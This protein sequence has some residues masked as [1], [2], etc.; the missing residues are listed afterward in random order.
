MA[1]RGAR[2]LNATAEQTWDTTGQG[3]DGIAEND[4][5]R[6]RAKLTRNST[7]STSTPS[8]LRTTLVSAAEPLTGAASGDV[9]KSGSPVADQ[10]GVWASG[11][12]IEGDPSL[13]YDA[14]TATL[15]VWENLA[16]PTD[17]MSFSHNGTNGLIASN[18]N[19]LFGPSGAGY[20]HGM[21]STH[22]WTNGTFFFLGKTGP[23][24]AVPNFGQLWV[25]DN[26]DLNDLWFSDENGLDRPIGYAA[27]R[28]EEV[29]EV[30]VLDH[31]NVSGETIGAQHING[32]WH[33]T[34]STSRTLLLETSS[35]FN[36]PV[37]AQLAIYNR[38]AAGNLTIND[39]ATQTLYLLDG[40]TSTDVG[41]SVIIGP[42][43]YATLIRESADAS[44]I[45]GAGL[46]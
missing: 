34:D 39:T 8:N 1:W 4:Q 18:T 21:V 23:Q 16:T 26:T 43:G 29:S 25:K 42:G 33:K 40:T 2:Y 44:V 5:L 28:T 14:S 12:T 22:L 27:Y 45:M 7:W 37:G 10:L 46:T 15:K 11:S 13:T 36:F 38:N 9:S 32:V 35:S 30:I 24:T 19:I 41:G 17:W 31:K 6:F 3:H 20:N